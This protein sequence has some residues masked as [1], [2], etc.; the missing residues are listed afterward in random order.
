MLVTPFVRFAIS[1]SSYEQAAT[2]S[3]RIGRR[4]HGEYN[5]RRFGLEVA[6]AIDTRLGRP[7]AGILLFMQCH[8]V[9]RTEF[10]LGTS[11]EAHPP[12]SSTSTLSTSRL[13]HQAHQTSR[14][15]TLDFSDTSMSYPTSITPIFSFCIRFSPR[16]RL[17]TALGLVWRRVGGRQ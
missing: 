9:R 4:P 16:F 14:G 3:A 1:F 10:Y 17:V 7:Y 12:H 15:F 6:V 11:Y 8:L 5:L 13:C 2:R